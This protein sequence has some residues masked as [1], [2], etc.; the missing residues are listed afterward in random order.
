MS[1]SSST[2]RT[3]WPLCCLGCCFGG[4]GLRE[5]G[6]VVGRPFVSGGPVGTRP[7]TFDEPRHPT[8]PRQ[9]DVGDA[10]DLELG[11]DLSGGGDSGVGRE[12][13]RAERERGRGRSSGG[14]LACRQTKRSRTVARNWSHVSE[15]GTG[16]ATLRLDPRT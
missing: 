3:R 12:R 6:V 8:H 2:R 9:V 15:S 10:R 14:G 7:T 5:R 1:C 11:L 4:G 16:T 13:E